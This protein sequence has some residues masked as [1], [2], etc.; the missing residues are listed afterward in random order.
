VLTP[1]SKLTVGGATGVLT[2]NSVASATIPACTGQPP[3]GGVKCVTASVAS[4]QATKLTVNNG[5]PVLLV[6][7]AV[8]TTG[9]PSVPVAVVPGNP[10]KLSAI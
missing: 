5:D 7:V 3:T 1:S 6:G 10:P 2:V 9:T 8:T 4:G